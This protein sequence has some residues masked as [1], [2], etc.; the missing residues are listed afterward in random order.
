MTNKNPEYNSD[1]FDRQSQ[2]FSIPLYIKDEIGNLH[3]S[4]TGTFVKYNG[5]HYIIFAEHALKNARRGF[6]SVYVFYTDGTR[7]KLGEHALYYKVYQKDDIVIVGYGSGKFDLKN[8]FD[9]NLDDIVGFEEGLFH[10][11][12]F[13]SSKAKLK[14]IHKTRKDETLANNFVRTYGEQNY[15]YNCK[16]ITIKSRI[17]SFDYNFITGTYDPEKVTYKYNKSSTQG[18]SP[19]GMSGGPMYFFKKGA[20]LGVTIEDTFRFAGIGIEYRK[21]KTIVGVA[22]KKIIDLICDFQEEYKVKR[23]EIFEELVRKIRDRHWFG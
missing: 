5:N 21:D 10:W 15:F 18:P 12:G 22:K 2:R 19:E 8:Y 13:P 6:D 14:V 3:F 16:Y 20:Q 23:I 7:K 11:T 9:L 17:K 4:S 1:E